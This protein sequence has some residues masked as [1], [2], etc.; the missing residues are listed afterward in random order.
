MKENN[1]KALGELAK[2]ASVIFTFGVAGHF[3]IFFFRLIAARHYGPADYGVYT[4]LD[5][6]K[7][8]MFMFAL[9]GTAEAIARYVPVYKY[10]NQYDKLRGFVRFSFWFPLSMSLLTTGIV[11]FLSDIITAFFGF[12]AKLSLFL[13]MLSLVFP[14]RVASRIMRRMIIANKKV[15][16]SSFSYE[17]LEKGTLLMA[18]TITSALNLGLEWLVGGLMLSMLLPFLFDLIVY[19]RKIKMPKAN[20]KVSDAREWLSYSIPLFFTT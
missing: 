4:L 3:L 17:I 15:L 1:V 8:L 20:T 13:K 6:I 14:F 18:A 12:P 2:K 19:K 16:Y 7:G 9:L 10:G 11:F 5:T